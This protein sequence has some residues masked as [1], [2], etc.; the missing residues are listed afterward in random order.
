MVGERDIPD[1]ESAQNPYAMAAYL[2]GTCIDWNAKIP[3]EIRQ[4]MEDAFSRPDEKLFSPHHE[5]LLYEPLD[6]RQRRER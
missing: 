1:V 2:L 3:T 6:R 4:I 5:S